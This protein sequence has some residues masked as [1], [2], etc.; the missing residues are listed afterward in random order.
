MLRWVL[1]A[2]AAMVTTAGS[3]QNYSNAYTF[4]KAV[5]DRDGAK[6]SAVVSEP[7]SVAINT[8]EASTGEGGLHIVTRGRD[9]G[10]LNF[11]LGKGARPDIQ[12]KS[13]ETPLA[14]AAR[15]GWVEGAQA[16]IARRALVDQANGRGETPLIIATQNRDLA[17]VRLL[18]GAGANPRRTDSA[19]GYSA[20]DYAKADTRSAAIVRLL[21]APTAAPKKKYGP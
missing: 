2:A 1:C 4:L 12:D 16:L 19:A 6:V 18:L 14:L 10:W 13:G 7:G 3:A 17:M 20:L 21:E 11:L 5:R 8:R 15:I 9:L